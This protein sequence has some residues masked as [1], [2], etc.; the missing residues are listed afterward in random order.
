MSDKNAQPEPLLVGEVIKLVHAKYQSDS[1][2][3]YVSFSD[4]ITNIC[5]KDLE[6]DKTIHEY[7]VMLACNRSIDAIY[8]LGNLVR[9]N[10][11]PIDYLVKFVSKD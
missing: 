2:K 6:F 10:I 1:E 4:W 8:Y 3:Q 11:I 5:L 7:K 9:K